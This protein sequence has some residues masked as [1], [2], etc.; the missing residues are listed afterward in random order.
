MAEPGPIRATRFVHAAIRAELAGLEAATQALDPAD[1]DG[2]RALASR[3]KTFEAMMHDHD[4]FEE[5]CVFPDVEA[6]APHTQA[7][8]E[9]EHREADRTLEAM[10]DASNQ[11]AAGSAGLGQAGVQAQLARNAIAL[12]A[13]VSLHIEKENTLLV[14]I[15]EDRFSPEEQ[16]AILGRYAG[17]VP[18]ERLLPGFAW[19]VER[20]TPEDQD[21]FFRTYQRMLPPPVFGALCDHVGKALGPERWRAIAG[22]VPDVVGGFR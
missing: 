8:Y 11:L 6:R 12:N 18:K 4:G 14:P 22:R 7:V 2:L 16:G 19:I 20:L 17:Y 13:M 5:T 9:L 1:V 21:A 3:I 15:I 10:V